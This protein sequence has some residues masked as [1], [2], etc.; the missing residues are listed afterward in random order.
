MNGPSVSLPPNVT[1]AIRGEVLI[2][3]RQLVLED[4]P[5]PSSVAQEHQVPETSFIPAR[6]AYVDMVLCRAENMLSKPKPLGD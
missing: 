1:G 2:S 6:L 4:S 5:S 3:V